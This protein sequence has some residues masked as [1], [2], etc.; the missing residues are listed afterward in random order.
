MEA[1]V[2]VADPSGEAQAVSAPAIAIAAATATALPLNSITSPERSRQ[3]NFPTGL[4]RVVPS[5]LPTLTN[6]C[7]ANKA[8]SCEIAASD[9]LPGGSRLLY[10]PRLI[11]QPGKSFMAS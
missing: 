5:H 1:F 8:I 2:A 11:H 10:S 3:T 6:Q 9:C 7:A 4:W